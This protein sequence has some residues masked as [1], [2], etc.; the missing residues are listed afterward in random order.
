MEFRNRVTL[1]PGCFY[2]KEIH[3]N[4]GYYFL[5]TKRVTPKSPLFV[6]DFEDT[7]RLETFFSIGKVTEEGY[8]GLPC[9]FL[10][11]SRLPSRNFSTGIMAWSEARR[12]GFKSKSI[13]ES[14]TFLPYKGESFF[15][16]NS[17]GV[18]TLVTLVELH[19]S[20]DSFLTMI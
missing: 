3:G 5:P 11:H 8:S 19:E 10:F 16:F 2:S 9:G 20:I 12:Q 15:V 14:D 4:E 13:K 7:A 17:P 1:E 18:V 6:V